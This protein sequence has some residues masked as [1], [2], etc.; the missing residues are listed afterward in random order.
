M[1]PKHLTIIAITATVLS[2]PAFAQQ[3]PVAQNA[4]TRAEQLESK[5][6]TEFAAPTEDPLLQQ[7]RVIKEKNFKAV[8]FELAK[9]LALNRNSAAMTSKEEALFAAALQNLTTALGP[10]SQPQK[11]ET[12][13]EYQ[14]N[15]DTGE[16]VIVLVKDSYVKA[17]RG[18]ICQVGTQVHLRTSIQSEFTQKLAALNPPASN[19]PADQTPASD[20]P[21]DST[22]EVTPQAPTNIT[23]IE[24]YNSQRPTYSQKLVN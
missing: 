15:P 22:V 6:D 17:N 16:F 8:E 12:Y 3:A 20:T 7:Y 14:E 18:D 11:E 9:E 23:Q 24:C 21:Q 2:H 5:L 19:A 13:F 10:V 1:N 4:D